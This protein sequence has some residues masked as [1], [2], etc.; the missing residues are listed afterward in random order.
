MDE[1]DKQ[2]ILCYRRFKNFKSFSNKLKALYPYEIIPVLNENYETKIGLADIKFYNNRRKKL[3]FFLNN[4]LY[5]KIIILKTDSEMNK[6]HI[7]YNTKLEELTKKFFQTEFDDN[8]FNSQE[9]SITFYPLFEQ[10]FSS[11]GIINFLD[12]TYSYFFGK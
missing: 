7:I 3:T 9:D 5:Q 11:G 10:R 1:N 8:Y 6:S 12:S 2:R 4:L